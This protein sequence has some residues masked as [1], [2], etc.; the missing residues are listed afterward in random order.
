MRTIQRHKLPKCDICEESKETIYDARDLITGVYFYICDECREDITEIKLQTRIIKQETI[1]ISK[2]DKVK[3]AAV[4]LTL[5]SVAT[6]RCPYCSSSRSVEPDAHYT[7]EC[8]ACGWDYKV[9]SMI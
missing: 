9:R 7:V 1:N 6:V 5:D 4:P 8:N 3:T 2:P